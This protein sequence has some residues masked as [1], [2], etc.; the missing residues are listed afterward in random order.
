[1]SLNGRE[2]DIARG[3]H[4]SSQRKDVLQGKLRGLM[5]PELIPLPLCCKRRSLGADVICASVLLL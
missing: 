3:Q 4:T 5:A 2:V 1:M